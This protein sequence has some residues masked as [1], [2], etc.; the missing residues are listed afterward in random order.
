MLQIKVAD[1]A[2]HIEI[3]N[4]IKITLEVNRLFQKKKTGKGGWLFFSKMLVK[5]N[6][7]C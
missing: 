2:T 5:K 7:L 6:P 4:I 3:I 1:F